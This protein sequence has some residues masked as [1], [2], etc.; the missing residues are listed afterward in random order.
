ML[1]QELQ[2]RLKLNLNLLLK[3]QVEILLHPS[4][5]LEQILKE[6]K[7]SNPF[8]EEVYISSR[9]KELFEER[10]LPEAR[11]EPGDM[12]VFLS[13]VRTELE[14]TDLEIAMEITSFLDERGYF[15]GDTEAI[16][17]RFGVEREYVEDL[18]EF[19]MSL[20]P[21]GV[22]SRDFVEFAKV[23]IKE[24]YPSE[25]AILTREL[26]RLLKGEPVP[27]EAKV[28]LSHLRTSPILSSENVQ[29][30]AK[31]DA[32]IELDDG[33]LVGYVYED[34]IE[35]KPRADY[36]EMLKGVKGSARE[37]LKE[38]QERYEN[39]RKILK[40]RK[41]N[42][43]KILDQ[44]IEVQERFLKGE[45][46]LRSLL[47]KDVAMKIGVSESTVSRLI[48]SKYVKTP[49]GTYPFKFFFV[50]ETAGGVSQEELMRRIKEIIASEDRSRPLSD[51]E[52]ASILRAEGYRVAR[53][54]VAKYREILGIPS[55]RQRR[56]NG[57]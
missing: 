28:K 17:K 44:I 37:F 53:R 27:E 50:R 18:R 2:L 12:E 15:R 6:E 31:V 13:N 55:S 32:V 9:A 35:I 16:A 41:E 46:S 21:V 5:E 38:Y 29:K 54:T 26:E 52:I 19:L 36:L 43:R 25:E 7:E 56:N 10:R 30:I 40:I 20:E 11:Y 22:C 34:F 23:Q 49:Q 4:Q 8:I 47:V 57:A 14:G 3:N 1:K 45:G 24:L 42:L 51:D 33:E 39:F 48:N